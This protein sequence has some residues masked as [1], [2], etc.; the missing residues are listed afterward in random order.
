MLFAL[1]R[2]PGL[3]EIGVVLAPNTFAPPGDV[4]ILSVSGGHWISNDPGPQTC[5][6]SGRYAD[7][8]SRN[9]MH[10]VSGKPISSESTRGNCACTACGLCSR[11]PVGRAS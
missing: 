7:S 5:S 1:V 4:Q 6:K 9:A 3:S 11:H 10:A 2:S 8:D